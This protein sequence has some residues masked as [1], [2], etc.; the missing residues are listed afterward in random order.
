MAKPL[1]GAGNAAA[2]IRFTPGAVVM[3]A[4]LAY[5]TFAGGAVGED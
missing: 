5:L 2:T 4:L 1:C 3:P